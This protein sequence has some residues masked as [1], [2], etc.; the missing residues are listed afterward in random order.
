MSNHNPKRNFANKLNKTV[1]VDGHSVDND[2]DLQLESDGNL[3]ATFLLLQTRQR[4]LSAKQQ[5][6][7]KVAAAEQRNR[8]AINEYITESERLKQSIT[9]AG[10]HT[11]L[12]QVHSNLNGFN[13]QI[14][15]DNFDR[16]HDLFNR[17]PSHQ[18]N[19]DAGSTVVES[20]LKCESQVA[21]LTS[22]LSTTTPEQN[23]LL[24]E[25]HQKLPQ[26]LKVLQKSDESLAQLME[27][28]VCGLAEIV[29]AKQSRRAAAKK[30]Q[31]SDEQITP[32]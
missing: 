7:S 16:N 25:E 4:M 31:E 15:A 10:Q 23:C 28:S 22:V 27:A 12:H 24:T 8:D 11:K 1:A 26:I 14:V 32:P 9:L 29:V 18:S 6:D 19:V 20:I 3:A 30:E 17:I 2:F 21:D 13:A 5:M